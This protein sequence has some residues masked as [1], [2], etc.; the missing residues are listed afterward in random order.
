MAVKSQKIVLAGREFLPVGVGT[1]EHDIEF[2]RLLGEA[3]LSDPTMREGETPE[4]Y[5]WRLMQ[6]VVASGALPPLLAC[7]VVPA[8]LVRE[9]A[10]GVW[11]F[12]LDL[13]GA[14][15]AHRS[16]GWTPEVQ[17]RTTEF[18]KGLETP[19]DKGLAYQLTMELLFPFLKAGLG[20]F[21]GSPR[22]SA[23]ETKAPAS[24]ESPG[25]SAAATSVP[26]GA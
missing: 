4:E 18:L 23:T 21:A 10:R 13:F 5:G 26:G 7:L 2:L 6:S 14:N 12:V 3:G 9:P 20:L 25:P 16:S 22:S 24:S 8:E 15:R 11:G 17:A 19:E 1:L